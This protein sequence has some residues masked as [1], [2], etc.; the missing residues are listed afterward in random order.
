MDHRIEDHG[1]K[2]I[3]IKELEILKMQN[4][5]QMD[6]GRKFQHDKTFG[7]EKQQINIRALLDQSIWG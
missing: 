3:F 7:E 2:T 5:A 4:A 6:G 1:L